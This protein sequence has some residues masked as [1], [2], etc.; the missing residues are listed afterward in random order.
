LTENGGTGTIDRL[1]VVDS[2]VVDSDDA[3]AT[4]ERATPEKKKKQNMVVWKSF[5]IS[6]CCRWTALWC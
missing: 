2:D 5:M 1:A 4:P 6:S 3:A